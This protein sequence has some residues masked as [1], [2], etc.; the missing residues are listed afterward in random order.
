MI[1]TNT[2]ATPWPVPLS[3]RL[4]EQVAIDDA[5][6]AVKAQRLAAQIEAAA[7]AEIDCLREAERRRG[8]AEFA[9]HRHEPLAPAA[10]VMWQPRYVGTAR[11]WHAPDVWLRWT[12]TDALLGAIVLLA[13][14][15]TA[16][17][18]VVACH[19]WLTQLDMWLALH[20]RHTAWHDYPAPRHA[21]PAWTVDTGTLTTVVK[22]WS[23]EDV[24]KRDRAFNHG[25]AQVL[26]GAARIGAHR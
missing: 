2:D 24:E 14:L 23:T 9:A 18:D 13:L 12:P 5:V 1:P 19:P 20:E 4:H 6:A 15:S 22:T 21:A 11:V 25:L 7:Q 10:Q 8:L 17:R 3:P 16:A 26:A